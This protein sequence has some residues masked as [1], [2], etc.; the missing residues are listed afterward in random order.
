MGRHCS[1]HT[2]PQ[3][4]D[5]TGQYLQLSG[6]SR[7]KKVQC[8]NI[9]QE[10]ALQPP[11]CLFPDTVGLCSIPPSPSPITSKQVGSVPR[12]A[13]SL[14]SNSVSMSELHCDLFKNRVY[15]WYGFI[16]SIV[17]TLSIRYKRG[18]FNIYGR[19]ERSFPTYESQTQPRRSM[20]H[21]QKQGNW[22]TTHQLASRLHNVISRLTSQ[23]LVTITCREM[24]IGFLHILCF[25]LS[26]FLEYSL[27]SNHP[28]NK[29]KKT[30][31][32]K[33]YIP[34]NMFKQL[35]LDNICINDYPLVSSE[36][37]RKSLM[38]SHFLAS[39]NQ[40]NGVWLGKCEN[41]FSGQYSWTSEDPTL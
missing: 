19:E 5:E 31:S 4:L 25:C 41:I 24:L 34:W 39:Q 7:R 10:L 38:V 33:K 1:S 28:N 3:G 23:L 18:S 20:G 36:S 2:N 26:T 9:N 17:L 30:L 32:R 6:F 16:F 35:L 8:E 15:L 21:S 11:P 40:N 14:T 37:R 13:P 12:L 22:H 27:E 29:N